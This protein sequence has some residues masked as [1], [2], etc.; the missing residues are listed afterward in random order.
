MNQQDDGAFLKLLLVLGIGYAFYEVVT[1]I[2]YALARLLNGLVTL[3]LIATGIL[4]AFWLYR[5]VTDKQYGETKNVR[6][7]HKLEQQR[8]AVAAKLP[9]HLRAQADE[10]YIEKQRAYYDLK[11][12]SRA[13]AIL[14]RTKQVLHV[15][16]GKGKTE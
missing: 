11:T 6:E 8:I 16:K 14:E 3:G 1:T 5:Y 13:D 10:Y 15:F 2:T 7:I 9:K 4:A 12:Y